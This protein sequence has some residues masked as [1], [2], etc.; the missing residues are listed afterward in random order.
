MVYFDPLLDADTP[1]KG[2][3]ID[4]GHS[5]RAFARVHYHTIPVWKRSRTGSARCSRGKPVSLQKKPAS[6]MRPWRTV[7]GMLGFSPGFPYLSIVPAPLAAPRLPTPRKYAAAGS[8]GIAGTQT[9]VYPQAS[10]G[11]WRIIGRTPV[12]IRSPQAQAVSARSGR[13]GAIRG[14]RGGRIHARNWQETRHDRLRHIDLNCDVGGG[15]AR[16][17]GWRLV[18]CRT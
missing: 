5:S 14:D 8:V 18:S 1:E 4:G 9:G 15:N 7:T 3:R 17:T 2:A 12:A 13:P 11:G 16:A 6:S 10:P